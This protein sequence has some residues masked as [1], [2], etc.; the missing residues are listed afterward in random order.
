MDHLEA[1]RA[2][3]DGEAGVDADSD[4]DVEADAE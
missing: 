2:A 1:L 4:T 3:A